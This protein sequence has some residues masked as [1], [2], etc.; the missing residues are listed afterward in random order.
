MKATRDEMYHQFFDVFVYLA[1][2]G[3][4]NMFWGRTDAKSFLLVYACIAAYFSRKMNRLVLLLSPGVSGLG[5]IAVAGIFEWSLY[6]V[7]NL[8]HFAL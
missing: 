3:L 1:P 4:L 8:H 6:Q 5:G 7:T 2:F